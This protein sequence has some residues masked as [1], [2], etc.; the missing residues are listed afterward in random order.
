MDLGAGQT[1]LSWLLQRGGKMGVGTY[2]QEQGK[3]SRTA[4]RYLVERDRILK[5]TLL[6]NQD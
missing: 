1:H 5:Q 3:C 2:I 6:K 4:W